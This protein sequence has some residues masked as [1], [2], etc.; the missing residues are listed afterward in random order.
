MAEESKYYPFSAGAGSSVSERDWGDMALDWSH[1]SGVRPPGPFSDQNSLGVSQ[2]TSN[3]VTVAPGRAKIA[4]YH[5]RLL[6]GH[7]VEIPP[8]DSQNGRRI[9]Y[10]TVTV[11][12]T[13]PVDPGSLMELRV[14]SGEEATESTVVPPEHEQLWDDHTGT[15]GLW[16]MPLARVRSEAGD[17][18]ADGGYR[19][20][21]VSVEDM[22]RYL[23]ADVLYASGPDGMPVNPS[24]GQLVYRSDDRSLNTFDGGWNPITH[25][26]S[27]ISYKP[28]VSGLSAG[29]TATGRYKMIADKLCWVSIYI[30]VSRRVYPNSSTTVRLYLPMRPRVLGG[31]YNPINFHQY[32]GSTESPNMMI[33]HAIVAAGGYLNLYAP[34]PDDT[35]PHPWELDGMNNENPGTCLLNRAGA[36]LSLS[37]VF[38]TM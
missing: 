3:T 36:V 33:G 37:G 25:L 23:G 10:V 16:D 5:Y 31:S 8:F 21:I 2:Q 9:D 4:G 30:T 26:G 7:D 11:D 34:D 20:N 15:P 38:E 22:R 6:T 19:P 17:P 13:S 32:S 35:D 14:R 29:Y 27:A 28:Q 18:L 12:A 1:H 24:A